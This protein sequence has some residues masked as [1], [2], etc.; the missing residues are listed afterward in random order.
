MKNNNS[1]SKLGTVLTVL[2]CLAAAVLFWLFA[3]YLEYNE[4]SSA[5]LKLCFDFMK[6]LP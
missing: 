5:A 1:N 3:K 2:A 4:D 6:M